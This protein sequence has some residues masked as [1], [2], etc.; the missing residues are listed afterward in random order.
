MKNRFEVLRLAKLLRL[1][2]ETGRIGFMNSFAIIIVAAQIPVISRRDSA[3]FF[4]DCA[5]DEREWLS[6]ANNPWQLIL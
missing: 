5:V 1:I 4:V 3:E 2:P 6:F